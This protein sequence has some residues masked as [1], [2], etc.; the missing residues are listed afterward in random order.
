MLIDAT[1]TRKG[2][3]VFL[4]GWNWDAVNQGSWAK[5][6]DSNYMYNGYV[7]SN[8][9]ANGDEIDFKAYMS[10]GTY[11]LKM[12]ALTYNSA[13]IVDIDIDGVEVASFDLYNA[14]VV[15]N[16]VQTQANITVSAAGVKT[17]TFRI[18]G[19]NA[20]SSGYITVFQYLHFYRTA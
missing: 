3:D 16:A 15:R 5:Y 7:K 13:G 17:I 14:S 2:S 9:A 19:K 4:P 8:P 11:T 10:A 20:S 1:K 18:D 12:M 6:I